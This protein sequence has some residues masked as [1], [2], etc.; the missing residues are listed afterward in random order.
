MN[1]KTRQ[2]AVIIGNSRNS[3]LLRSIDQ[4]R[5]NNLSQISL[6]KELIKSLG[7]TDTFFDQVIDH[8]AEARQ[9]NRFNL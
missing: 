7:K 9:K 5:L 4:S 2:I 1:K 6:E 3:C 8:F